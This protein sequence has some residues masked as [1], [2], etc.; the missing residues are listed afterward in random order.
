MKKSILLKLS[1]ILIT[2]TSS[3]FA[4]QQS[5][6]WYFGTGAALTFTSGSPVSV[7][8]SS[9][10]TWEGCATISDA[11]TGNLLFYTDGMSV[12][13]KNNNQMPNGFGLLGD[14]TSTQSGVIVP[15]PDSANIYYIFTADYEG[16]PNGINYNEVDMTLNGGLGDVTI[17]NAQILTP[18]CEKIC[19]VRKSNGT[20]Y[21]VIVHNYTGNSFYAYPVTQNGVGVPVVTNI[22]NT[23]TTMVSAI[24]YLKASPNGKKLCAANSYDTDTAQIFDFNNCTGVLSNC[25]SIPYSN[26]Y[27]YG[28][29]FSPNNTV[30]YIAGE[31]S[32]TIYQYDISSNNQAAI[33]AS[34][35]IV[36]TGNQDG[37]MALQLGKDGKI[38]VCQ[39]SQAYLDAINNPNVLGAGCGYTANAVTL[40]SGSC[41][42]GLPNFVDAYNADTLTNIVGLPFDTAVCT[43]P[44]T[45]N[46]GAGGTTYTWSTGA[47][48]QSITVNAPGT[49]TVIITGDTVCGVTTTVYDTTTVTII[50]VPNVN[51]GNDTTLCQG[52]TL[53][54]NAGY[55][56]A[57]Y[58]WSTGA[59][60]QTINVNTNGTYWVDLS[61]GACAD[62]D[63]IVVNFVP[64]PVVNLGNDTTLCAGQPITLDA[65]N[66]GD[67]YLWSNG[68]ITQTINP[69][70]SGTYW[71]HVTA[72]GACVATDSIN[73]IFTPSPIV[74]LGPDQSLCNGNTALLNAGNPGDTYAWSTG[75]NT[76]TI[77]VSTAGQYWVQVANGT[78]IGTDTVNVTVGLLANVNLGP[79]INLCNGASTTLDAGNPGMTYHWSS[80]ETTQ[81][82]NVSSSGTYYVNVSNNGCSGSDTI[83]VVIGPPLTV[84]LG[85]DTTICPGDQLVIDAGKGYSS[86][87][88]IPGGES[89]HLIIINKPGTYGIT[90]V[91]SNGCI[92]RTSIW[93]DDFC[94][95]DLYVPSGFDPDGNN[96]NNV[97]MAYCDNIVQFHIYVYNRWGQLVFESE[98]ISKGW[99]GT[100]NGTPAPQDTYVYRIDY[101]LYD[102]TQVHK[103][104]KV[105]SVTLIR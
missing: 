35:Y 41:G 16:M 71:V 44:V 52:Q 88:W 15:H 21:W 49:Y 43:G 33:N 77:T 83:N 92:A 38:Y 13:D 101:Q 2:L 7:A 99:D 40:T 14:Q 75:A 105:G 69:T 89:S 103:H 76:Q 87:A 102:Y 28:V 6:N 84:S 27:P 81:T 51:L 91:D 95:S 1:L 59:N 54:L 42:L 60:T 58:L 67:T 93:V 73:I 55:A 10:G 64:G 48:T 5:N 82:I 94:P 65:G 4:Q 62:T 98:D 19:A 74:N 37:H 39:G 79:D 47:N 100:F 45:L 72:N 97:F 85:P 26:V 23:I 32:G 25:I 17:K 11:A 57:T 104:N 61:I 30:L 78:C 31:V 22:G 34:Q 29:S 46:A 66:P 68:A 3:L 12:W 8:G 18:A 90:V 53:I 20:D 50:G 24:G 86:Y 36:N 9:I 70:L 63:T 80:G 96:L 56:G